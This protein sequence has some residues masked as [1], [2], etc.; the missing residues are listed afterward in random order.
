M[1]NQRENELKLAWR[2]EQARV[3][4]ELIALVVRSFAG[5]SDLP[6]EAAIR[7]RVAIWGGGHLVEVTGTWMRFASDVTKARG[8]TTLEQKRVAHRLVGQIVDA[9]RRD[10]GEQQS[11]IPDRHAVLA[12]IFND[13]ERP[14]A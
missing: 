3:Y 2:A 12:M 8:N 14:D 7:G 4:E 1:R 9:A 13:Y 11:T 5:G 6:T 10:L